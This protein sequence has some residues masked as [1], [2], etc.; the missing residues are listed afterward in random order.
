MADVKTAAVL[1]S[2]AETLVVLAPE[3]NAQTVTDE[4]TV[5][6]PSSA[7]I[8]IENPVELPLPMHNVQ[9]EGRVIALEGSKFIY[10]EMEF[11]SL[12]SAQ[13]HIDQ[14]GVNPK[15]IA[16]SSPLASSK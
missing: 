9:Y 11:N 4:Q 16:S 12:E 15:F 2:E 10:A 5:F 13:R 14:L 3:E 7:E 6:E 8:A 1:V